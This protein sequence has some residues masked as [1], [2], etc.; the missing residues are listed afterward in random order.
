LAGKKYR[1]KNLFWGF[2]GGGFKG[3]PGHAGA[4]KLEL[5]K[6]MPVKANGEFNPEA[7]YSATSVQKGM[8]QVYKEG[9]GT[10]EIKDLSN[11]EKQTT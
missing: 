11:R 10:G 5:T 1:K 3:L 7:Q 8:R 4:R 6:G 2:G 9:G